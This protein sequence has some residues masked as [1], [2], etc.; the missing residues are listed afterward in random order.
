MYFYLGL[1]YT[2]QLN[3]TLSVFSDDDDIEATAA[4]FKY[5][6]QVTG[7]VWKFP[8]KKKN[9]VGIVEK[10]FL[11]YG[12]V[13]ATSFSKSGCKF[14][15]DDEEALQLFKL[16]GVTVLTCKSKLSLLT[17]VNCNCLL[18][19]FTSKLGTPQKPCKYHITKGNNLGQTSFSSSTTIQQTYN[20]K[21]TLIEPL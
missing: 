14:G 13:Q 7:S 11:F 3:F 9:D 2:H 5:L 17:S 6:H 20:H 21:N 19:L 1:V 18:R 10:K 16:L 15:S 12:P 4:E 8:K